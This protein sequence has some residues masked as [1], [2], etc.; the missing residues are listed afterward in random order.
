MSRVHTL[1]SVTL[2]QQNS[3][4]KDGQRVG[5]KEAKDMQ[6]PSVRFSEKLPQN[7]STL[8][9]SARTVSIPL[10]SHRKAGSLI[11][12]P[13]AMCSDNNQGFELKRK[14]AH[15]VGKQLQSVTNYKRVLLKRATI[16]VSC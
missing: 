9:L 5:E 10:S 1:S 6:Q 8:S 7:I 16:R 13:V 12:S 11:S 3:T 2:S 14:N 15:E 4:Q